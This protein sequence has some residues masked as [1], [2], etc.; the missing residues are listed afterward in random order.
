MDA[1]QTASVAFGPWHAYRPRELAFS[2]RHARPLG[3][4]LVVVPE[5]MKQP[6]DQQPLHLS[7]ERDA[8]LTCLPGRRVE[9]DDYIPQLTLGSPGRYERRGVAE[10]GLHKR[11]T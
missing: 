10:P 8:V 3:R 9:A 7:N 1:S 4:L 2:T 11:K 5:Q 6:M